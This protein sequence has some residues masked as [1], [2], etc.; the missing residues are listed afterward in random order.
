MRAR[1][2][3]LGWSL[4]LPIA[5]GTAVPRLVD[6]WQIEE[7][8]SIVQRAVGIILLIVFAAAGSGLLKY[9]HLRQDAAAAIQLLP[10]SGVSLPHED[11]DEKNCPICMTLHAQIVAAGY[12]PLLICLGLLLAYLSLIAPLPVT[13]PIPVWI[14]SRGPPAD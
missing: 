3:R 1:K 11:H 10:H 6:F 5:L 8:S 13:R 14:E 9:L 4:A 7:H 2:T 12:V